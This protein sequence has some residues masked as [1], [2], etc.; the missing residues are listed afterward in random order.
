MVKSS[1]SFVMYA[2]TFLLM[3]LL[4]ALMAANG[5]A[6]GVSS[7]DLSIKADS[8]ATY[9]GADIYQTA[10]S[11]V[12][13]KVQALNCGGTA[14]FWVKITNNTQTTGTFVLRAVK[15]VPYGW[16]IAYFKQ[17]GTTGITLPYT[18]ATL[19]V[20]CF[21]I[22]KVVIKASSSVALGTTAQT[23]IQAFLNGSDTVVR[24][25]VK[26]VAAVGRP[27]LQI[28]RWPD[29]LFSGASVYQST[30]FGA[31]VKQTEILPDQTATYIVQITNNNPNTALRYVVKAQASIP[32]GW[33]IEYCTDNGEIT[34]P[35]TTTE[36]APK[37]TTHIW[38]NITADAFAAVG[39]CAGTI[40]KAFLTDTDTYVRDSVQAI[41]KTT[42]PDLQIR[43]ATGARLSGN[44]IYQADPSG[45]Q[46]TSQIVAPGTPAVFFVAIQNDMSTTRS[47]QVRAVESLP[48]EWKIAYAVSALPVTLPYTTRKL[49]P[50]SCV[51]LSVTI[52]PPTASP[53]GDWS[54]VKIQA[55]LDDTDTVIRDAVE[56][57]VKAGGPDLAIK[58]GEYADSA[59]TG[60]GIYQ[61]TPSGV[62]VLSETVNLCQMVCYHIRVVNDT[63]QSRRYYLKATENTQAGWKVA[64]TDSTGTAINLAG[65]YTTP[66]LAPCESSLIIVLVT[67]MTSESLNTKKIVTVPVR[68][69]ALDIVRDVVRMDTTAVPA[70]YYQPDLLIRKA[71]DSSAGLGADIYNNTGTGQTQCQTVAAGS[72]AIYQIRI[73]NDG[74]HTDAITVTGTAGNGNWQVKYFDALTGGSDVTALVTTTGK[75]ITLDPDP[76][77]FAFLR[78]EVIPGTGASTTTPFPVT[79]TGQ[80]QNDNSKV[81]AVVAGTKRQ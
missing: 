32:A 35:C 41:A 69:N 34:L 68:L 28:K 74:N 44:N 29:A 19:D 49:L 39:S 21:E 80:S 22:I 18:T 20:G 45:V 57:D 62:Q 27:D 47:F 70:P 12:Q 40:I 4:I 73:E 33:S 48:A 9:S 24:D 5:V 54:T 55:F 60:A 53:H 61:P 42:G 38:V 7:P 67:A 76:G 3:S 65:G 46:L 78:M 79:V 72:K 63:T 43:N 11:G 8:A 2:R 23:E 31:Q 10:A 81:D 6:Q 1:Q 30:P 52:T 77:C 51:I 58:N 36:I 59:Y 17:Y 56:A 66:L 26:A 50:G 15:T 64:Y 25:A 16:S 75:C 37:G 71:G 14:V 13:E